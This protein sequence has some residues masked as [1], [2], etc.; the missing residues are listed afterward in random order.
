MHEI[1]SDNQNKGLH[2]VATSFV[3]DRVQSVPSI[4][5]FIVPGSLD[6]LEIK[7]IVTSNRDARER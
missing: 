3:F 6:T 2:A 5:Y 1:R 4:T 7:T